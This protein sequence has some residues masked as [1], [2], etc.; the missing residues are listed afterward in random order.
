MELELP[1]P[2]PADE[3]HHEPDGDPLWSESYYFD[4]FDPAGDLGGYV[5]I[6]KYPNLGVIW[7]WACVV[8]RDR[9]L[10][11]VIDHTVP[12]PANP[13]S[14][15]I[16]HDGLWADHNVETPFDHFSLGLEAFGLTLDDPADVY[17]GAFGDKTP[18]AFDLEWERDGEVFRYPDWLPRYEIPCRVHGEILV[19]DETIE[20]DGF[21][22]RDHS[23]GQRDW[24]STGWCW[25]AFRMDDGARFH[26]VTTKPSTGFAI[27]YGQPPVRDRTGT[28]AD[29]AV[30]SAFAADE[31]LGAAGIPTSAQLR[32][33]DRSF[34]VDPLAWSPVLCVD[35]GGREDRFPRALA[36]F[37][38]LGG[39]DDGRPGL[40][41][42]EFNQPPPA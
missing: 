35:P 2:T 27:G 42:I 18:I 37:T 30:V 13:A 40:G 26:A 33:D 8:G 34:Q 9:R 36:T 32:I 14:L 39:A 22:Q 3:R 28:A 31:V 29:I 21:G 25:T 10:V 6:G 12:I 41:W 20:L 16:R 7:Y 38:E 15:E 24:W 4:F 11:T 17:T 19:G 1:A 23:W 5:R